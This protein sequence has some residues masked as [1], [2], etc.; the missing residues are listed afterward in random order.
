MKVSM[1][2]I[3]EEEEAAVGFQDKSVHGPIWMDALESGELHFFCGGV[4]G[5]GDAELLGRSWFFGRHGGNG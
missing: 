4:E 3:T 1:S 2:S 5:G